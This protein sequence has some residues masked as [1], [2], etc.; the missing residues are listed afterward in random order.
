MDVALSHTVIGSESNIT[1]ILLYLST[2]KHPDSL[3][4]VVPHSVLVPSVFYQC[5][6]VQ[7]CQLNITISLPDDVSVLNMVSVT[8]CGE[9]RVGCGQHSVCMSK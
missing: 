9:V 6:D 2:L 3:Y 7:C 8:T 4:T 1:P 5:V